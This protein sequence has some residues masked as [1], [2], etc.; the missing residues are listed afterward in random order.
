M[1][2]S[3]PSIWQRVESLAKKIGHIYTEPGSVKQKT[4][5]STGVGW[6]RSYLYR[7]SDRNERVLQF[8]TAENRACVFVCVKRTRIS[9]RT[10]LARADQFSFQKENT[11]NPH[12][13]ELDRL[14][15]HLQTKQ[16]KARTSKFVC[17]ATFISYIP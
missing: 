14:H 3:R 15:F 2:R 9:E 17:A 11:R 4:R 10:D 7:M 5:N 8:C 6:N 1:S 16:P 12:K 13:K